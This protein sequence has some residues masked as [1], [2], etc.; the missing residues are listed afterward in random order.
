MSMTESYLTIL[1]SSLDRKLGILDSLEK[2]NTEQEAVLGAASFDEEAFGHI[3]GQKAELVDQLNAMDEGFQ[4]VYDNVKAEL[5]KNREGYSAEIKSLQ[6]QDYSEVR[7][8][9]QGDWQCEEEPAVC[10]ELLQDH[11]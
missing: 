4:L 5:D 6:G 2:L 10:R 8:A 9:P 1:E 11:E 7:T 3:V